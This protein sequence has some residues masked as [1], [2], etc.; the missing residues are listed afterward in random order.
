MLWLEIKELTIVNLQEYSRSDTM[1]KRYFL[2]ATHEKHYN[3]KWR[4]DMGGTNLDG[5]GSDYIRGYN[6]GQTVHKDVVQESIDS[7]NAAIERLGRIISE[8]DEKCKH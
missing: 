5:V 2:K 3:K 4:N 8:M 6:R 1:V 7:L